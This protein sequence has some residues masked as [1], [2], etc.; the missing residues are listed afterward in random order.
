M[1]SDIKPLPIVLQDVAV[2]LAATVGGFG[3]ILF[4]FYRK[5]TTNLLTTVN[6]MNLNILQRSH[7]A[8]EN[9]CI[10]NQLFTIMP[11]L[12]VAFVFSAIIIFSLFGWEFTQSGQ[13]NYNSF[14]FVPKPFS[15]IAYVD[16]MFFLCSG[17]WMMVSVSSYLS[18][19][20]EFI[21]RISFHF[22]VLAE[23]MR[24]LRKEGN[25]DEEMEL[26]KLKSLIKDLNLLHR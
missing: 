26:Q 12:W 21:L 13:P 20:I 14:F 1:H 7:N 18:M 19:H 5:R 6:E 24:Q 2:G 25:C 17:L 16:Q 8:M 9:R 15:V 10:S 11:I 4:T 3:T 23:E 22:R